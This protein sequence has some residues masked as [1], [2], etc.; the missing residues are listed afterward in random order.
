M[1][2]R[3]ASYNLTDVSEMFTASIIR[4]IALTSANFYVTTRRNIRPFPPR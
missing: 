1:S 4:A 3:V 2:N